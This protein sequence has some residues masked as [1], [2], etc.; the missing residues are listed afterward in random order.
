M[1]E[2]KFI[3]IHGERIAVLDEGPRTR[4]APA[5]DG[6]DAAEVLLLV[7]GIAGSSKTWRPLV[8]LLATNYRV[9]REASQ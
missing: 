7:H 4:G 5:A 3:D 1:S 8:P 9:L 2:Y 6:S